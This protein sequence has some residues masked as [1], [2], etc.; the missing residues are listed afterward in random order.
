MA[1][2]L[3]EKVYY[4]DLTAQLYQTWQELESGEAT[5]ERRK[6]LEAKRDQLLNSI[7]RITKS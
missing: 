7:D 4:E 6:E 3:N 1:A 5:P 2:Q